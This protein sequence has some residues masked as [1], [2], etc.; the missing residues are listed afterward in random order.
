MRRLALI[1][2]GNVAVH[3]HLPGW[4]A[5]PDVE[6]VAVTDANPERRADAAAQAPAARWYPSA[7]DLLASE[8]VDFVDICT[9]PRS[10][11][12]LIAAALG[13]GC[14]VLCEKPLVSSP[15]EL[16]RVVRLATAAGRVLH[17]V[18]NWH[19]APIVRRAGELVR[20]GAI[21]RVERVLWETLRTRP[22]A[23][24]EANWRIDPAMAGGGI[25]TDHGWHTFY[26]LRRWLGEEP[27]SVRAALERRRHLQWPVEDTARVE[28]TFSQAT[29]EVFLTWAADR[30]HTRVE[31]TGTE[32]RLRLED[33]TLVLAR[34]DSAIGERRWPCPPA[35]SD[36]STHADWFGPVVERFLAEVDGTA[37][38][39]ENLAE[40]A[41][42]VAVEARARES[43]ERGEQ[44]L[45]LPPSPTGGR[46][47]PVA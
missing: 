30:R 47:F 37:P 19:H 38:R 15:D 36:G 14:H 13:R 42:C 1:G 39:G 31:L 10:H 35:M 2:L 32:G 25:L 26:V 12:G 6:L 21:G 34:T 22:A 41:L 46:R 33:D 17:T 4:R 24:R 29:A 3:G 27:R 43:S 40:A 23:S 16:A 44:A 9:P 7:E 11:A 45:A 20:D 18:H 8:A 28:L 5:R